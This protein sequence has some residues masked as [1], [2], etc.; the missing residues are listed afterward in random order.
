MILIVPNVVTCAFCKV[1]HEE[2]LFVTIILHFKYEV[3][4]QRM[5]MCVCVCVWTVQFASRPF[6]AF[7]YLNSVICELGSFLLFEPY[8]VL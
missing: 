7:L 5:C 6:M 1:L 8:C 4:W 2:I 3:W